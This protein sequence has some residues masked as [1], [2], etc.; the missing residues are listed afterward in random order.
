MLSAVSHTA[1]L[2]VLCR[3]FSLSPLAVVRL[4]LPSTL[5]TRV[6]AASSA[7]SSRVIHSRHRKSGAL[8]RRSRA[9]RGWFDAGFEDWFEEHVWWMLLIFSNMKLLLDFR[10]ALL[11]LCGRYSERKILHDRQPLVIGFRSGMPQVRYFHSEYRFYWVIGIIRQLHIEYIA[12]RQSPGIYNVGNKTFSIYYILY[13]SMSPFIAL[14]LALSRRRLKPVIFT[15]VFLSRRQLFTRPRLR[16]FTQN[17][18]A[19]TWHASAQTPA[20]VTLS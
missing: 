13:S 15:I 3:H 20:K 10:Q 19:S 8:A 16:Y 2:F 12:S 18:H 9:S 1:R 5:S 7:L 11:A 4:R 6:A 14:A 17:A